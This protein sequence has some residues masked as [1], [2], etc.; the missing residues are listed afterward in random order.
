MSS[1]Q[2]VHGYSERESDRLHDQAQTLIEFLHSGT[3]YPAGA[4]VLEAGCGVGAQTVILA[5]N[6]PKAYFTSIDISSESLA[7]AKSQIESQQIT[8]VTVQKADIFSLPF[9]DETFD[10]IFICFV[11]EHLE[12]PLD[13]LI[14]LKRVLKRNGT[15]TVIEGDHGSTY[16]YPESPEARKTIQCLVDLQKNMKGSALIG[17]QLYPLLKNAGYERIDVSPKMIYVDGSKPNLVDGFTKKTFI[18]MVEGVREAAL[19]AKM[20]DAASWDKGI[21]DM[22]RTTEDYGTFCYTFFKGFAVNS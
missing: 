11:L 15:V 1:N 17:R 18:A 4:N 19:E 22:Y 9:P 5:K 8:N 16:F 14:E 21:H 20:M 10:H 6:S 7:K 13:A 2:Y 3:H 12:N